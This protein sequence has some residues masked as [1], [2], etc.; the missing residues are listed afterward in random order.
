[1][2]NF[3]L[4]ALC[5][6]VFVA[7]A[8]Y[9]MAGTPAPCVPIQPC[10]PVTVAPC[11]P[12]C[13]DPCSR[14]TLADRIAAHRAEVQARRAARLCVPPPCGEVVVVEPCEPVAIAPCEPVCFDPCR[15]PTL[16]D[17]IA[18]HHAEVL[19]RRAARLCVPPCGPAPCERPLPCPCEK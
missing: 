6:V 16:A 9:A 2:K 12:V 5:A 4:S 13:V 19:A 3:V 8:S 1:M 15:R 10:E 18:A 17:R 11:E 7:V 14:P